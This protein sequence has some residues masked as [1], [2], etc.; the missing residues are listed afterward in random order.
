MIFLNDINNSLCGNTIYFLLL[1][2]KVFED[3]I[4]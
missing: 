2:L 3:E 4:Y 1:E